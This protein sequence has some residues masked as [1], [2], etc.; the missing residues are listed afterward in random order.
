MKSH[1]F[2]GLQISG[3]VMKRHSISL[4]AL[5]VLSITTTSYGELDSRYGYP[6]INSFTSEDYSGEGQCFDVAVTSQNLVYVANAGGLLEYDGVHWRMVPGTEGQI[7]L[8]VAVDSLD[9]IWT[10]SLGGAGLVL[11][12]SNGAIYHKFLSSTFHDSLYNLSQVWRVM[13]TSDGVYFQSPDILLRWNASLDSPLNGEIKR[14]PS[15]ETRFT[16]TRWVNNRLFIK[17]S[18]TALEEMINDSL[19]IVPSTSALNSITLIDCESYDKNTVLVTNY[20]N[21]PFLFD[22]HSMRYLEG[23]INDYAINNINFGCRRLD[24][25]RFVLSSTMHGLIVFDL[26]GNVLEIINSE[27]GLPSSTTNRTVTLD[28]DGGTWVPLDYGVARI[29]LKAPFRILDKK[30]DLAGSVVALEN[31]K[32]HLFAGTTSGLYSLSMKN[33]DGLGNSFKKLENLYFSTWR[34]TKANDL[35]LAGT[36]K[37]LFNID[38]NF[39]SDM[40]IP[41]FGNTTTVLMAPNNKDIYSVIEL[42]GLYHSSYENGQVNLNKRIELP[43]GDIESIMIKNGYFWLVNNTGNGYEL[44]R[45][46]YHVSQPDNFIFEKVGEEYGISGPLLSYLFSWDNKVFVDTESGLKYFNK[47]LDRF[48]SLAPIYG[49]D[50]NFEHPLSRAKL[51]NKN[52]LFISAGPHNNYVV[53]IDSLQKS[54]QFDTPLNHLKIRRIISSTFS[55]ESGIV[56][57]GTDDSRVIMYDLLA[58][59]NKTIKPHLLLR[60]IKDCQGFTLPMCCS[61]GD[62]EPLEL[63]W[64]SNSLRFE[65]ALTSHLCSELNLYRYR[66]SGYSDSWSSWSNEPYKDFSNLKIGHYTFEVIGKNANGIESDPITLEFS[67]FPPWY[68]TISAR[69]LWIVIFCL[70]L[71]GFIRFRLQHL[72]KQKK[73]LEKLVLERTEQ[74]QETQKAELREIEA[75]KSAEIEAERLTT[76]TQLAITISHEFNNPLAVIQG[77]V[78]LMKDN[79]ADSQD[80]KNKKT[81]LA[82]IEK[83]K[84]LVGKLQGINHLKEIDYIEGVKMLD[85]HNLTDDEKN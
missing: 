23:D 49:Q 77:R 25:N 45:S 78:E 76:V 29:D 40:S 35:L 51:L 34:L 32:N 64:P 70:S 54:L 9:R 2:K 55:P 61:N 28:Q 37:G 85:I 82:Q 15:P 18:K 58:D 33:I 56:S 1:T 65:Y 42:K 69:I 52:R 39:N 44:W 10:G 81:V 17:R 43:F 57:F 7:I 63:K 71:Y 6:H 16:M 50:I 13:P 53:R 74:L 73:N 11:P 12:D 75:R 26:K 21:R 67:I 31:Y 27:T 14:W 8:S 48:E 22:D 60:S 59:T 24:E 72:E 47:S 30:N 84:K 19:V 41:L 68:R 38:E 46:E 79:L 20:N 66:L 80:E 5:L 36:I 4:L 62:I 3:G 83:M